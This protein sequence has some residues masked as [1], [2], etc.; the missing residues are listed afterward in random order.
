MSVRIAGL[1]FFMLVFVSCKKEV[2]VIGPAGS[3]GPP[4]Q[5][6]TAGHLDTGTIAGHTTLYDE[7]S[8][9]EN[10]FS[11]IVIT[12]Q[13]GSFQQKDT[14][15]A[16]GYYQFHGIKTDTYNMSFEKT[17]F[18]IMNL[19]GLSHIAGGNISTAV[20]DIYLLQIPRKTAVD[21]L[22]LIESNSFYA[23]F[24]VTLDTASTQYVQYYQNF[25]FYVG[26]DRNVN[27]ANYSL[28]LNSTFTPD[29]TGGYTAFIQKSSMTNKIG[30]AHV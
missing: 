9:K 18:G 1:I 2:G 23:L 28:K 6:G 3:Q 29:G 24:R 21:S 26:K 11:G 15:D 10:D 22:S 12:L 13:S 30:R 8:F 25:L 17:G 20:K 4:G 16:S 5:P 19:F 14:T 7:F 27:S